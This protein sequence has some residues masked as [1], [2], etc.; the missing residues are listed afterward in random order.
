MTTHI[1][2]YPDGLAYLSVGVI[3]GVALA[4]LLRGCSD[5]GKLAAVRPVPDTEQAENV[6]TLHTVGRGERRESKA[7]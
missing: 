2:Q 6:T 7:S 1:I 5:G 3:F 4:L